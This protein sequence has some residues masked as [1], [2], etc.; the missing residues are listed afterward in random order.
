MDKSWMRKPRSTK[1]YERG[2]NEV[3][4]MAFGHVC[5]NGKIHCPCKFCK[6]AKWVNRDVAKDHLT[7]DG[8]MKGYTNWVAHGEDSTSGQVNFQIN[9]EFNMI[10]DMQGLVHDAF[11]IKDTDLNMEEEPNEQA[12]TFYKSL[13]DAR[14]DLYPGCKQFS[15]LAFLI[16]LFHLK[17]TSKW[18]NKTFTM[19]L[20]LLKEAFPDAT[21]SLP[22][23]YYEVHKHENDAFCHV[24]KA[25]RYAQAEN[26]SIN[27][28]DSSTKFKKIPAKVLRYFPLKP[29]LQRIFMSS[30]TSSF[31]RWHQDDRTK[32]G[33]MRHPSDSP[34]SHDFDRQHPDFSK[35][36]R[37]VENMHLN[38]DPVSNELRALA[39]GPN[40]LERR[41]R[42]FIVNGFRFHDIIELDYFEGGKIVLFECDWVSP[43]RA[44]KQDETGFTLVNFSRSRQHN[45]PFVLAS[46]AQQIFYIEDPIEKGWRV[47]VRAKA[48]DPFDMDPILS[49]DGGTFQYTTSNDGQLHVGDEQSNWIRDDVEGIIVGEIE[50][51]WLLELDCALSALDMRNTWDRATED[52]TSTQDD[53]IDVE[54]E[55]VGNKR[56]RVR[57][58]TCMPKIWGQQSDELVIVS[59][60]DL[61]Q[62][63]DKF[64]T[65]T[66]SHFL[67]TIARNGRYCPLHYKDWRLML[68]SHKDEMLKIVKAKFELQPGKE[69]Y[70]L[71]SI[72][73]KWRNWKSYVKSLNFDPNIPIEQQMLDI[74]SRVDEDQYKALVKHW[75]SDKSKKIS[76][77]NKQT[78]AKLELLHRMGKKSFAMEQ[79][80]EVAEQEPECSND[81]DCVPNLNDAYAKIM[82]QDK[83]GYLRMYGMRVTPAD[84]CGAIPG[85]D[86]CNRLA[87]EYKS[88]YMEAI[89]KFDALNVKVETLS[90]L[91][92][93]RAQSVGQVDGQNILLSSSNNLLGFT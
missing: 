10:D 13:D 35:Y 41:Y 60:N 78:R 18:S 22:K 34:L 28:D 57:G 31:M 63:N 44:Q 38:G 29:R 88:K 20:E 65:C 84:V 87:M 40:P 62:P 52:I 14:Q 42:G 92:N 47:V 46:Q 26:D 66:L 30:K 91:V 37:N 85:R 72:N 67:G 89:E 70:I 19:L 86:A 16:R 61:G 36:A 79:M 59:F 15:K 49:L 7:V 77:K 58:P 6:N 1:D 73:K 21:Q 64:K 75:M 48:R 56:K 9:N 51:L 24:C 2:L 53:P 54:T 55:P 5:L 76:E 12:K 23:P 45:E 3:L 39:Q 50:K 80:K 83:H 27:E 8:F 4:D 81:N 69:P 43:R 11:G 90:A 33:C 25:S 74:P 71:K 82:G 93:G 68:R 32:D 17:C